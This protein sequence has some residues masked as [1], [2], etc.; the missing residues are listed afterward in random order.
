MKPVY[1]LT[2][3]VTSLS[4][5][6]VKFSISSSYVTKSKFCFLWITLYDTSIAVYNGVIAL[7]SSKVNVYGL[8]V[9]LSFH[10]VNSYPTFCFAS[11]VI[12]LPYGYDPAG[13]EDIT[14]SGSLIEYSY[15]SLS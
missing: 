12:S 7:V 13:T 4:V 11:T 8:D 1:V 9:S 15:I 6:P 10:L 14:S 2:L 3:G 5:I